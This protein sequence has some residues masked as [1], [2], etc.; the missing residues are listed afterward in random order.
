[1]GFTPDIAAPRPSDLTGVK[2][3]R[4]A[5]HFGAGACSPGP[6]RLRHCLT[7]RSRS[8]TPSV[9]LMADAAVDG[10]LLLA[11]SAVLAMTSTSPPTTTS[12]STQPATNAEPLLRAL[13]VISIRM[14]AMMDS[15]L[16]ST[17]IASGRMP[18]IA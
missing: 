1:M 15:T 13:G 14:I 2:L 18:P 16:M 4:A 10:P 17:P 7:A 5:I 11:T 12:P 6:G 9:S 8:N 3:S